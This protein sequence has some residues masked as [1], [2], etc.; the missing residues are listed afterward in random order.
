VKNTGKIKYKFYISLKETFIEVKKQGGKMAR[1]KTI[2]ILC[3]SKLILSIFSFLFSHMQTDALTGR[4]THEEGSP[5]PG[6]EVSISSPALM[7]T[8]SCLTVS[9]GTCRFPAITP[10]VYKITIKLAG[11]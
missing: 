5:L 7:G 9:D 4:V 8:R 3:S 6:A 10:G 11:I 1:K 2:Q